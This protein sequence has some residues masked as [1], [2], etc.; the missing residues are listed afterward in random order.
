MKTLYNIK[1]S[2]FNDYLTVLFD[3]DLTIWNCYN[4]MGDSLPAL[5]LEPPFTLVDSDTVKDSKGNLAILQP[6]VRDVLENLD[7]YGI[8]LGVVSASAV[9]DLADEAQPALMLLRKLDIYQFFNYIVVI[10][11]KINKGDYAKPDGKTLFID[12]D[13]KQIQAVNERGLVDVLNRHSFADWNDLFSE[14]KPATPKPTSLQTAVNAPLPTT[15]SWKSTLRSLLSFKH[16]ATPE[17]YTDKSDI[18]EGIGGGAKSKAE[19]WHMEDHF[20]I[21]NGRDHVWGESFEPMDQYFL[22]ESI[23]STVEDKIK[24]QHPDKGGIAISTLKFSESPAQDNPVYDEQLRYIIHDIVD[25]VVYDYVSHR[26]IDVE[27]AIVLSLPLVNKHLA[28]Q[29]RIPAEMVTKYAPIIKEE[30]TEA[31]NFYMGLNAPISEPVWDKDAL[32]NSIK[33]F[34]LKKF[35]HEQFSIDAILRIVRAYVDAAQTYPTKIVIEVYS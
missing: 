28:E 4:P 21:D 33:D 12:D 20:T 8:N 19:M 6:N 17:T 23:P 15:S 22:N 10:K 34:L 9:P 14:S 2:L 27:D 5:K 32:A 24:Q 35:N 16:K 1:K 7:E 18:D 25:N 29:Y 26:D 30:I 11:T 31:V 13:P 3:L